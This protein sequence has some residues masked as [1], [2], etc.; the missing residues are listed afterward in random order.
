MAHKVPLDLASLCIDK[1]KDRSVYASAEALVRLYQWAVDMPREMQDEYRT[2]VHGGAFRKPNDP[3]H[4]LLYLPFEGWTWAR[5]M[6]LAALYGRA[7]PS[8]V[9]MRKAMETRYG[10]S[11]V[12]TRIPTQNTTWACWNCQAK[13]K[14]AAHGGV[15]PVSMTPGPDMEKA[16]GT[17]E[18]QPG[19]CPTIRNRASLEVLY[20]RINAVSCDLK[21]M[22][23]QLGHA[24]E[25]PT[26]IFALN[27]LP[28]A[29]V[30]FEDLTTSVNEAKRCV[31]QIELGLVSEDPQSVERQVPEIRTSV[32]LSNVQDVI[33]EIAARAGV[34][35]GHI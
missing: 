21:Q 13:N 3:A 23:S 8:L 32:L 12:L 7:H 22:R 33:E 31:G 10:Q 2:Y 34:L 16:I 9:S 25:A 35:K 30:E 14:I 11:D 1:T 19:T 24:K 5:W 15:L 26:G 6:I 27:L 20:Q 17:M 18:Q 28:T 4:H 29:W